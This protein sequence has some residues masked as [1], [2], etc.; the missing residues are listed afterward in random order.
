MEY[1]SP[2]ELACEEYVLAEKQGTLKEKIPYD[3]SFSYELMRSIIKQ[4]TQSRIHYLNH[5]Q[6][7]IV[8]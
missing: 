2:I 5:S 7:K 4:A 1:K 8:G 3:K 6:D